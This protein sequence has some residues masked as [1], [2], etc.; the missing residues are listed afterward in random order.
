MLNMLVPREE[1][2]NK[3]DSE[4]KALIEQCHWVNQAD[5][6]MWWQLYKWTTI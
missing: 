3:V 2:C 4:S 6:S 5:C 1:Q